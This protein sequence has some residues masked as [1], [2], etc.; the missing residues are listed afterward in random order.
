M[1]LERIKLIARRGLWVK[2]YLDFRVISRS[3][4]ARFG[5]VQNPTRSHH[6]Q[7][8]LHNLRSYRQT[9]KSDKGKS[10]SRDIPM[11]LFRSSRI[12]LFHLASQ[13]RHKGLPWMRVN[14]DGATDIAVS[15]KE[16]QRNESAIEIGRHNLSDHLATVALPFL[17]HWGLN[18]K[19]S[20]KKQTL[21]RFLLTDKSSNPLNNLFPLR[22]KVIKEIESA[23]FHQPQCSI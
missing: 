14:C 2:K 7:T 10:D 4:P 16:N 9:E 18:L 8:V 17:F 22:F 19:V 12:V 13:L 6:G 5:I 15:S 1:S 20:S 3:R 21:L 23:V 11:V